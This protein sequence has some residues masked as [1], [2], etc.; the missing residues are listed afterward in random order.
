MENKDWFKEQT[1]YK[2]DEFKRP[3]KPKTTAEIFG[4]E[5]SFR[6]L[7]IDQLLSFVMYKLKQLFTIKY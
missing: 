3:G 2:S 5:G 6:K 4:I 7:E 1:L